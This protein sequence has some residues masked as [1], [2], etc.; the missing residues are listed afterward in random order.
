MRKTVDCWIPRASARVNCIGPLPPQDHIRSSKRFWGPTLKAVWGPALHCFWRTSC[1]NYA[2][3]NANSAQPHRQADWEIWLVPLGDW[4]R[5]LYFLVSRWAR[6]PARDG[7]AHKNGPKCRLKNGR[8]RVAT[9]KGTGWLWTQ[10]MS[11][12]APARFPDNQG[13]NRENS[14]ISAR[15]IQFCAES[16]AF[17]G[18]SCIFE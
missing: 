11:N 10:S 13:K 8:V 7:D 6:I 4:R 18:L 1:A 15:H 16:P 14:E 12:R 2:R 3:R 17:T 5:V 9:T